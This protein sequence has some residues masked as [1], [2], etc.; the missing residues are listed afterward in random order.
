[1]SVG[2]NYEFEGGMDLRKT[3]VLSTSIVSGIVRYLRVGF[4]GFRP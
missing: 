2:D 4:E 3:T 1:V